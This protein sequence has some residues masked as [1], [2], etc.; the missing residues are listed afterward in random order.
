MTVFAAIV[1]G[2]AVVELVEVAVELDSSP[3]YPPSYEPSTPEPSPTSA[4]LSL[5]LPEDP[6]VLS[7]LELPDSV[8]LSVPELELEVYPLE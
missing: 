6:E 1:G 8:V 7:E 4:V 3:P 2:V 5:E